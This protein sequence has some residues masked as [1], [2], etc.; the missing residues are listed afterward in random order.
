VTVNGVVIAGLEPIVPI[1]VFHDGLC[2]EVSAVVDTGSTGELTLPAAAIRE[3]E[4]PLLRQDP[5]I[6]ADGSEVMADIYE[7]EVMWFGKVR[8][9]EVAEM[10]G[11]PLLGMKLMQNCRLTM[12]ILP[13]AEFE[14][15]QL[16]SPE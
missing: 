10:D 13:D 15:T 2:V 5:A 11:T 4:L 16:E 6:L 12:D 14:I 9:V 3:L 8:P 1:M 7:A